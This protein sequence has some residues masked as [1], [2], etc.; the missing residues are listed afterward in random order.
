VLTARSSRGAFR[1]RLAKLGL[2]TTHAT[3]DAAWERF[4]EVAGAKKEVT[5]DD[6]QQIVVLVETPSS[7]HARR[8]D[9]NDVADTLR[10]LIFG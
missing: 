1:H 9:D 4:L 5:D 6:L 8:D 7:G 2:K 3:D 10:H